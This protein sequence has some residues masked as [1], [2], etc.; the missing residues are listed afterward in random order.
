MLV[1]CNLCG[2]ENETQPGQ[3]MLFCAYCGCSLVVEETRLCEHLILPHER[4]D[5]T[6]QQALVS[7]LNMKSLARAKEMKIEFAFVPYLM[8]EDDREKMRTLPAPG[9]PSW[10]LPLPHPP[11]GN[12]SFFD[13][14][15][16]GKEKTFM[17]K[18]LPGESRKLL[19]IPL[20][21]IRYKAAGEEYEALVTAENLFVIASTLPPPRPSSVNTTNILMAAILFTAFLF[22]GRLGNGLAGRLGY[23]MLAATAGFAIVS[24]RERMKRSEE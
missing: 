8:I 18:E 19:H 10:S 3:E 15:L 17:P 22:I 21:R 14:E 12:Y 24:I 20:Y 9:A 16:A 2:G 1:R 5:K 7:F 6:A 23:I 4:N 11:S 13:A